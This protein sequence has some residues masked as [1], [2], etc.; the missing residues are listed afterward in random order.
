MQV[1]NK[2]LNLKTKHEKFIHIF[3]VRIECVFFL[4][5]FLIFSIFHPLLSVIGVSKG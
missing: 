1:Y 2:L 4:N 3:S 5:F